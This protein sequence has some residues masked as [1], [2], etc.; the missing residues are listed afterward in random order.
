MGKNAY[1]RELLARK[2]RETDI[3][4]DWTGQLCLDVMTLVLN[5]PEVMGKNV[6]GKSRLQ[7]IGEAFNRYY[8][9]CSLA[10]TKDV[11]ASYIREK[12]D[13]RL[14]EIWGEDFDRWPAR[15]TSWRDKGI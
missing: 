7:K 8:K 2:Q 3:I 13:Q 15:Y 9:E 1:A 11:E 5:D 12:I 6:M 10:L 4:Q 14:I